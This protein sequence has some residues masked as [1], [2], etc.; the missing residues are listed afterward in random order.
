M[1][2]SVG[3]TFIDSFVYYKDSL[4][5]QPVKL[6]ELKLKKKKAVIESKQKLLN[7]LNTTHL[8]QRFLLY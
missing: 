5:P 8:F 7:I 6:M 4:N 2:I 1:L 3:N